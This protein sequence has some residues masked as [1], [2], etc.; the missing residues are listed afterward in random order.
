MNEIL[1]SAIKYLMLKF[2]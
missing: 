2:F 1:E